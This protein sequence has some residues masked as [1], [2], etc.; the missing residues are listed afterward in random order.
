MRRAKI[1]K[2]VT[3]NSNFVQRSKIEIIPI[4]NNPS[5][6]EEKK[7]GASQKYWRK[8]IYNK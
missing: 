8:R 3:K 6:I 4:F 7:D 2:S 1:N 5:K